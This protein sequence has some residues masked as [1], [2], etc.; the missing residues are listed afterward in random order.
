MEPVGRTR[1]TGIAGRQEVEVVASCRYR[2]SNNG[3]IISVPS[4]AIRV[5]IAAILLWD[6]VLLVCLNIYPYAFCTRKDRPQS[7]SM[8][9]FMEL[10]PILVASLI[11]WCAEVNGVL[12]AQS[13]LLWGS[14]AVGLSYIHFF[15]AFVVLLWLRSRRH[16]A[17]N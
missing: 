8:L 13:I 10:V 3:I 1:P 17:K 14:L 2:G 7:F 12:S 16:P 5:A 15:A 11:A 6:V 4:V 9:P